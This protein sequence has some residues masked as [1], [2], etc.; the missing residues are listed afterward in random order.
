M[1]LQT[2]EQEENH[3]KSHASRGQETRWEMSDHFFSSENNATMN[4]S[5]LT[6]DYLKPAGKYA[7]SFIGREMAAPT[8]IQK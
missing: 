6:D 3:E 5:L 2:V 8:V 4:V 1:D 7:R